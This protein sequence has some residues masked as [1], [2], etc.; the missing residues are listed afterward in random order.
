ME[1]DR[2]IQILDWTG[3]T[4]EHTTPHPHE[5]EVSEAGLRRMIHGVV[6]HRLSFSRFNQAS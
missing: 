3:F 6:S 2:A 5:A 1:E 4:S